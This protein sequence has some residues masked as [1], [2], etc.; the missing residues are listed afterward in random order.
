MDEKWKEE[1]LLLTKAEERTRKERADAFKQRA[2]ESLPTEVR[3]MV[4][5]KVRL[6]GLA[7]R[8]ELNGHVGV[9]RVYVPEKERFAVSVEADA[10]EKAVEILLKPANLTLVSKIDADGLEIDEDAEPPP[11][12]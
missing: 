10:G 6:H 11:L 9:A 12:L 7:A 4:L 2:D 5:A 3:E 8:P 1:K